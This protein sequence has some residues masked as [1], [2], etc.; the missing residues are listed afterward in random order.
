[1]DEPPFASLPLPSGIASV[2][3]RRSARA[4]RVFLRIN[5]AGAVVVILPPRATYKAGMALL[6]DHVGWVADRLAALPDAVPFTDGAMVPICGVAHR[7]RHT[8]GGRGGAW[9]LN[10]E[11]HVAGAPEFLGRRVRDF[12]RKE[13]RRRLT[14]LSMTKASL[15]GVTPRRV[16]IKDTSSRWGSCTADTSLAFSWRLVMAPDFVQDYVAAHEVAHLHHMNHGPQFWSLVDELTPHTSAA[17]TWLRAEGARLLRIGRAN[18]QH[19]HARQN[20]HGG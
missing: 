12:L 4:R 15:I 9:I 19:D 7:I 13:G 18:P 20:V 6:M 17:I 8:A 3:W 2:E 14:A 1:M 10:Q 5:T 16:T 11:L